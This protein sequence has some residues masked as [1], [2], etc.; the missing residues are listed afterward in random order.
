MAGTRVSVC[1]V[2]ALHQGLM[3]KL[4]CVD[5]QWS[6]SRFLRSASVKGH[7]GIYIDTIAHYTWLL[8]IP[9]PIIQYV[10]LS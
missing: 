5:V 7:R 6:G 8:R 10:F 3:R 1:T 4:N 2:E 9:R